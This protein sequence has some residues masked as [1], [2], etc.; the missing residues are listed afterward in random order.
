MAKITIK[1]LAAQS[2]LDP[3]LI[4]AVVRQAGG[5]AAFK[6]RAQDV[7]NHGADAGF[8]G[9][10]YY[11][12]TVAFAMRYRP[13][14]VAL[15]ND[16][17]ANVGTGSAIDLVANFRCLNDNYKPDEVGRTLYGQKSKADTQIANALAWFALEEVARAYCD[18]VEG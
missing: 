3:A 16:M 2:N 18:A 14:I 5:W 13:L 4:R 10:I 7:A 17:A 1:Q 15:C 9:F 12:D 6:E 11:A 8:S